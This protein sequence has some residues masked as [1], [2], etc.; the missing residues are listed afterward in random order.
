MGPLGACICVHLRVLGA[1]LGPFSHGALK[2]ILINF[3]TFKDWYWLT[4]LIFSKP[5]DFCTPG[6]LTLNGSPMFSFSFRRPPHAA[7][8]CKSVHQRAL[9]AQASGFQ[10][11]KDP[12]AHQF[13]TSNLQFWDPVRSIRGSTGRK[14]G[15][16]C[17]QFDL[18]TSPRGVE[19]RGTTY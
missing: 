2:V 4:N 7:P 16:R 3:L 10:T 9:R 1:T 18:R 6:W 15:G 8:A 12:L 14:T 11:T 19:L 17:R 5:K 13:R